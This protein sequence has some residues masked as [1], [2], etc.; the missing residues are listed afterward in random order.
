MIDN[1]AFN[2]LISIANHFLNIKPVSVMD[3]SQIPPSGD[4]HDYTSRGPYWWP[5]PDTKDGLPYIRKDGE[6]NP[7]I[8]KFN[9]HSNESKITN[10]VQILSLA[11]YITKDSKYA[12]K[13]SR[14]I[15]VW[16]LEQF[17]FAFSP[18]LFRRACWN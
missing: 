14:L 18:C 5:N 6:R 15:H 2:E 10:A 16:F 11:Y 17:T 1:K 4:K 12:N 8:N 3:K 13:A 9:D 7:A